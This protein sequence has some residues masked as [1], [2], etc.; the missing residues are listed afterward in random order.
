MAYWQEFETVLTTKRVD[1][2]LTGTTYI[3]YAD[4]GNLNNI[5]E[6]RW[7]IVKMVDDGAGLVTTGFAWGKRGFNNIWADRATLSYS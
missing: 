4:P 2:T 5:N 3:W 6:P 1:S 7:M